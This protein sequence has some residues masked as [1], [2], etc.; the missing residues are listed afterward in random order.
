[1]TLL[2]SKNAFDFSDNHYSLKNNTRESLMREVVDLVVSERNHIGTPPWGDYIDLIKDTNNYINIEKTEGSSEYNKGSF[3]TSDGYKF[4]SQ[5]DM[6][7]YAK[8][9][10]EYREHIEK[11]NPSEA[12]RTNNEM[13]YSYGDVHL[14]VNCQN[15]DKDIETE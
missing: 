8:K 7:F 3:C 13:H 9:G 5:M 14:G 1:M 12:D 11:L 15:V 10:K 6:D 4:I 2:I